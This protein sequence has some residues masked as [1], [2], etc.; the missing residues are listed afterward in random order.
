MIKALKVRDV[1]AVTYPLLL[2]L[3]VEG[4]PIRQFPDIVLVGTEK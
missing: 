2:W 3:L 4:I 1:W